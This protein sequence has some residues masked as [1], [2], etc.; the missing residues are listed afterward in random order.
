LGRLSDD[1]KKNDE[2]WTKVF[3]P[4]DGMPQPGTRE[5]SSTI[6]ATRSDNPSIPV[7]VGT[8]RGKG[9]VLA[10]AGD[11]TH[12]AWRRT[13]E[14]IVAYERFWRQMMLWLARQENS[15]GA[16]FVRIDQR[17]LER[18][19]QLSYQVGF[20]GVEVVDAK[21]TAKIVGPRGE[22]YAV[23]IGADPRG[24]W[25]PPGPGEYTFSV[26]G[27]GKTAL[28]Q[29][30]GGRDIARFVVLETDRELLRPAADHDFLKKL[31]AATDGKFA[32]P[33]VFLQT[34][35]ELQARQAPAQSKTTY[36]PD[37]R[38]GPPSDTIADQFATLWRSAA[39]FGLIVYIACLCSEWYL[40]RR[41]GLV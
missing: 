18:P 25:N 33:D 34:L 6:F 10:F 12:L 36:W 23:P 31:A 4:L 9:R 15:Q 13:P 8:E 14:A 21:F 29:P 22:E 27:K 35:A 32:L 5:A 28:G 20:R 2:I 19:K 26:E 1:D 40:R 39:L 7:L 37:W 30:I 24:V 38:K 11:T 17:R 3:D 16:V 41:W